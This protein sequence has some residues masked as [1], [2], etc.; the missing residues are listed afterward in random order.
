M[1]FTDCEI[2]DCEQR[3]PEWFE[4]RKG[5]LTASEFGP[6]LLKSDKTSGKARETAIC[7]LVARTADA[8]E[9]SFFEN[10]A[11]KRGTELEPEALKA[12]QEGTGKKV[13]E[14]GFCR[15][16]YGLFG[17]SP[18]GLLIRSNTGYENKAPIPSTHIK[19]RRAGTL[20]DEYK[21]QVLGSMAVTGAKAWWFQSYNPGLA[22]LRI[23]IERNDEVEALKAALIEFSSQLKEALREEAEAW[24]KEYQK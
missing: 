13:K 15:S 8:W 3:S 2:I 9:P 24:R 10:E 20:P 1:S 4:A 19:Y 12:F 16:V 21:W 7:K 18:D 22:P 23:L 11:M 5:I 17:C 14:V 6:W